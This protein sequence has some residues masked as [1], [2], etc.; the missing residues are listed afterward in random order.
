MKAAKLRTQ[1]K[2][3][4]SQRGAAKGQERKRKL[5]QVGGGGRSEEEAEVSETTGL[6]S[7]EVVRGT[8]GVVDVSG[9][10]AGEVCGGFVDRGDKECIWLDE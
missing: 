8:L 9:L 2:L 5:P 10:L 6:M 7:S 1:E 4:Q 3:I